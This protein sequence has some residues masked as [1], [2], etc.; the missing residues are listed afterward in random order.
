MTRRLLDDY[1]HNRSY[2]ILGTG[3]IARTPVAYPWIIPCGPAVPFGL[4]MVF[5]KKI[6]WAICRLIHHQNRLPAMAN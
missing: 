5:D 3:D 2:W 1:E 6:V 4:M